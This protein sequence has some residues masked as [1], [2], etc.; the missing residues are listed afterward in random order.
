MRPTTRSSC[1]WW[2]SLKVIRFLAYE[3]AFG[4]F[5]CRVA[6]PVASTLSSKLVDDLA[7]CP[8]RVPAV[9]ER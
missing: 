3:S 4:L 1:A 7:F 5:C 8:G 6:D 9:R 2:F